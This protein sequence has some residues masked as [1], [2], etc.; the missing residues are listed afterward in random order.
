MTTEEIDCMVHHEIIRQ[1]AYPSPLRYGNF[2][3]SVCTSVNNVVCHG[4][5]DRYT[6][7]YPLPQYK[8]ILR[9]SSFFLFFLNI[10]ST[11]CHYCIS[12]FISMALCR[13]SCEDI[14]KI[15]RRVCRC[16][17]RWTAA[18]IVILAKASQTMM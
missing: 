11:E 17:A 1:N 6:Y 2:P 9:L 18:L 13:N 16:C 14:T 12:L 4:I 5:P 8:I 7:F 3:K 10:K 15:P